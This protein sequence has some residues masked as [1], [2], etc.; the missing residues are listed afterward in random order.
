MVGRKGFS[1]GEIQGGKPEHDPCG[2]P[3]TQ[4]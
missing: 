1:F 3:Q 4:T 2:T